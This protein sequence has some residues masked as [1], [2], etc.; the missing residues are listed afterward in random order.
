MSSIKFQDER[1]AVLVGGRERAYCGLLV[2]RMFEGFLDLHG[3]LRYATS[4]EEKR[5]LQ[6]LNCPNRF[7]LEHRLLPVLNTPLNF[8]G[9]EW[10]MFALQLNTALVFGSDPMR[11]V[12]RVHGQCE[13][14]GYVEGQDRDWLAEIVEE[15]LESGVLR[16]ETQGYG[17]GWQDLISLLQRRQNCPVVMSYSV[18]DGFPPY[19]PKTERQMPWKPALA[20]L[21]AR[22]G[23]RLGPKD[24]GTFRFGDGTH[25]LDLSCAVTR[26]MEGAPYAV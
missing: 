6:E 9:R 21:R 3:K 26:V 13:I 16:P 20:A 8:A 19:D 22:P 23:W 7:S 15:G 4:V 24:W 17:K 12:A 5:L 2:S 10:D 14:H 11:F 1:E 18:T 25:A